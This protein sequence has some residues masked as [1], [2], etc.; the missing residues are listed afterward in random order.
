MK[1][2]NPLPLTKLT[3]ECKVDNIKLARLR[4]LSW[5]VRGPVKMITKLWDDVAPT[6]WT[7]HMMEVV[8][9]DK[10]LKDAGWNGAY[11]RVSLQK[12]VT[13][14]LPSQPYYIFAMVQLLG[15]RSRVF[16]GLDDGK[17]IPDGQVLQPQD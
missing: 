12:P 4:S 9:A 6:P 13:P 17:V 3:L 14:K 7:D 11:T 8:E 1:V 10:L 15:G 5:G 2:D 16:V